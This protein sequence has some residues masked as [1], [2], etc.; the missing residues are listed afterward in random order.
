MDNAIE[1]WSRSDGIS[2][3]RNDESSMVTQMRAED[4]TTNFVA[5]GGK[6]RSLL[7][8]HALQV[9]RDNGGRGGEDVVVM[10]G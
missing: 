6:P 5:P 8:R 10:I 4:T 7:H 9:D 2:Y 1:P 3:Y